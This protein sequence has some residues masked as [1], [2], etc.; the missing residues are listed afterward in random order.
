MGLTVNTEWSAGH[1]VNRRPMS[2]EGIFSSTKILNIN[3]THTG[4]FVFTACFQAVLA[5]GKI[6][7]HRSR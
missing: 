4:T 2:P 5:G 7:V 3:N 6:A 1:V